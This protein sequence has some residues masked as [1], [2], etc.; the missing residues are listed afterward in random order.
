MK[1]PL[2]ISAKNVHLSDEMEELIRDKALKLDNFHDGIIGCRIKVDMPHRSQRSGQKYNVTIDIT[3]PGGEIVVKREPDEDLYVAISNSFDTAERRLK[4]HADRQRGDI[5]VY[6]G[7]PVAKVS[8]IF[9]EEGYG[10]L[11]TLVEEREIYFHENSL[12]NG[13]FKDLEVGTLV[14]F[15]EQ[16]GEKGPQASS[17]SLA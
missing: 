14:Q 7:K 1:L 9:Y 15:V 3:V 2:E 17:V 4:E 11:S 8:K 16:E 5:R 13:R 6:P 12:I 10:F